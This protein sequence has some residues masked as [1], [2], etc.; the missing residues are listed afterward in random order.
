MCCDKDLAGAGFLDATSGN[1]DFN[2]V[3]NFT[4]GPITISGTAMGHCLMSAT[5]VAAD[6]GMLTGLM[7]REVVARKP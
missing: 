7:T 4:A 6:A 3:P 2:G 1:N 5:F